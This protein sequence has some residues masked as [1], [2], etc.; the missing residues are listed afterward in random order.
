MAFTELMKEIGIEETGTFGFHIKRVEELIE[1]EKNGRYRLNSL[2]RLAYKVLVF[3]EKGRALGGLAETEAAY[4]ILRG[5][6]VVVDREL[7]EKYGK[8]GFED[9]D[10]LVFKHDVD[11]ELFKNAV[12]YI[13]NTSKVV[14]PKR[15]VKVIYSRVEHGCKEIIVYEGETSGRWLALETENL[16]KI[17][18]IQNF[19]EMVLTRGKLEKLRGEGIKTRIDNYG[20]LV[21]G[22]DIDKELFNEVV[23][24]VNSYGVIYAPKHLYTSIM[25]KTDSVSGVVR[26]IEDWRKK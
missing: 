26:D 10:I 11:G 5:D 15:L 6:K 22:E 25:E 23:Y 9:I 7:L 12:L 18:S 2:G 19:G 1:R 13:R 16:E 24:S 21:F 8:V 20:I 17:K 4:K 14:I 3:G